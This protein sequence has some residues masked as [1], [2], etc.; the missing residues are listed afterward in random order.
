MNEIPY[1]GVCTN[2]TKV[3]EDPRKIYGYYQRTIIVENPVADVSVGNN[4]WLNHGELCN[5]D[6]KFAG[7]GPFRF[8]YNFHTNVNSSKLTVQDDTCDRWETI[9]VKEYFYSHF[10]PKDSNSYVLVVFIKNEVSL[11]K[12]PI[13][14]NF[15][16]GNLRFLVILKL[17]LLF[18]VSCFSPTSFT[19]L[20]R[21]RSRCIFPDGSCI[22]C[23]WRRLLRPKSQPVSR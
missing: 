17:F 1:F 22:D 19:T 13:G 18:F 3:I 7:T 12:T 9:Q 14:V 23:L 16:E 15:Y 2:N 5:L 11:I 4:A 21:Y 6:I 20:R 10:F 8:C